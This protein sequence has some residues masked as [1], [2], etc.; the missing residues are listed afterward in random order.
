MS[1]KLYVGGFPYSTTEDELKEHFGKAGN[2]LSVSII[3]DKMTGNSKGFGFIEM[4]SDEEAQSAI[5]MFNG[6][7]YNGRNLTVNEARPMESRPQKFSRGGF[8]RSGNGGGRDFNRNRRSD[9]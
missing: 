1:K 3:I 2:V 5:S 9:W 7:A 4:E 6:E 8:S